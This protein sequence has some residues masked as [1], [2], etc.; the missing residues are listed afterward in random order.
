VPVGAPAKRALQARKE[1]PEDVPF[2][3]AEIDW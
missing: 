3:L 1:A 2:L